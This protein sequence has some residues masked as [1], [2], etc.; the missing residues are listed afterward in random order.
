MARDT[1]INKLRRFAYCVAALVVVLIVG[2]VFMG[3][4]YGSIKCGGVHATEVRGEVLDFDSEESTLTVSVDSREGEPAT[5]TF[6]ISS[7]L[8]RSSSV[9]YLEP[10]ERVCVMFLEYHPGKPVEDAIEAMSVTPIR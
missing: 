7:F 3:S 4:N 2:G 1:I 8:N 6:D 5:L 10:G 9:D